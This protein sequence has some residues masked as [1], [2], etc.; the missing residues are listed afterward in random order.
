MGI[1]KKA[2]AEVNQKFGLD[3]KIAKA[4]MEAADEVCALACQASFIS[5]I[6]KTPILKRVFFDASSDRLID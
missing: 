4:V 5:L 1:L 2:S 3:A 6:E